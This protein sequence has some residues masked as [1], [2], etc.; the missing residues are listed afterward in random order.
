MIRPDALKHFITEELYIIPENEE[1]QPI[2][3]ETE[4]SRDTQFKGNAEGSVLVLVYD[5]HHSHIDQEQEQF[6]HKILGAVKVHEEDVALLNMAN[7][8]VNETMLLSA[9]ANKILVFYPGQTVIQQPPPPYS[10][11]SFQGKT[12]LIS[13]TLEQLQLDQNKK[14]QLWKSLQQMFIIG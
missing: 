7:N 3:L 2:P 11:M 6:L 13:D 12:I 14:R 10:P 4:P 8:D 5:E 1:P 9:T